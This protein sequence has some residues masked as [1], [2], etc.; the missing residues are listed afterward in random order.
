ML[1]EVN[2]LQPTAVTQPIAWL[3][4]FKPGKALRTGPSSWRAR[5][6]A[7]GRWTGDGATTGQAPA[8]TSK[9]MARGRPRSQRWQA[10]LPAIQAFV[11][12]LGTRPTPPSKPLNAQLAR[13]RGLVGELAKFIE[14]LQ[15]AA[16]ADA[17]D[18]QDAEDDEGHGGA[19]SVGPGAAINAYMQTV[20][21]QARN[22]AAKRST[23]KTTPQR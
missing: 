13:N 19:W 8:T 20:R 2:S 14:S 18:D 7:G 6:G 22:A 17:D 1:K 12:R 23:N 9:K 15:R 4:T 11:A 21:T 16:D 3:M 10:E 5:A